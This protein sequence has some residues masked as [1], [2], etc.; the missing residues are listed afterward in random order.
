MISKPRPQ[1]QE[2]PLVIETVQYANLETSATNAAH[3]RARLSSNW[4]SLHSSFPQM[5]FA[6]ENWL[7]FTHHHC[8][9]LWDYLYT[10]DSNGELG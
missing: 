6:G 10:R 2:A 4:F 1:T 7:A 9:S 8:T 3:Y 5:V